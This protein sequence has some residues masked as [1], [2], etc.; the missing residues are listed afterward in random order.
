[1]SLKEILSKDEFYYGYFSAVI[2]MFLFQIVYAI[3]FK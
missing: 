3:I 1:M 2:I